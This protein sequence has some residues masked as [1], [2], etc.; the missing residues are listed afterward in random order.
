[1]MRHYALYEMAVSDF[2]NFCLSTVKNQNFDFSKNKCPQSWKSLRYKKRNLYY[3]YVPKTGVQNFKLASSFFGC[4]MIQ[5]PG[6]GNDVTFSDSIL[7]ASK[8]RTTKH[9]FLEFW[10]KTEK[11][12]MFL[13]E[14]LDFHVFFL[15]FAWPLLKCKNE[16]YNRIL[17]P[18][19]PKKHV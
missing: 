9:T 13:R 19:W 2:R 12:G 17:C 11:M 1:M 5:K 14:S 3:R 15:N 10:H 7:G 6:K 8:I 4:A 18:K 16:C